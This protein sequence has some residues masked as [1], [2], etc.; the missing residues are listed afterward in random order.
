MLNRLDDYLIIY[1]TSLT[2]TLKKFD[3]IAEEVYSFETLKDEW[4]R[5]CKL[6]FITG[7]HLWKLKLIDMNKIPDFA[8]ALDAPLI[9]SKNNEESFKHIIRDL[10]FH[11]YN[12]NFF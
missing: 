1:H 3:L 11:M 2:E 9:I 10:C 12:N 8:Q 4:K 7:L 5:Y 6:S